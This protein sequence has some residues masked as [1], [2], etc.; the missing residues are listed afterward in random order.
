[1]G[2]NERLHPGT[3]MKSNKPA[4]PL[5]IASILLLLSSPVFVRAE[6]GVTPDRILI[7]QS[8]GLTGPAAPQIRDLT[9]GAQAYFDKLNRAGGIH[10]RQIQLKSLDDA[11]DPKRT[12]ENATRLIHEDGAFALFLF[13][14][15]PNVEAVIPFVEKERVPLVA[16]S[17]GAESMYIPA[18]RYLFPV[19][20][21]YDAEVQRMVDHMAKFGYARIAVFHEDAAFGKDVLARV[22][23]A[24]EKTTLTLATAAPYARGTTDVAGAAQ[25][26]V[27]SNSEAVVLAGQANALIAFIEV[28]KSKG[29]TPNY[30]TLSTVSNDAFIKGLGQNARGVTLTQVTPYPYSVASP[31]SK[32]FLDAIRDKPD[33]RPSYLAMEGFIGAKLLA[34]GLR[35]AGPAPTREKLVA[36][37]E[38]LQRHDLGGVEVTYGPGVR[39]GSNYTDITM[40]DKRGQLIH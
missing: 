26:V 21:P 35:R 2:Y 27:A 25:Q 33:V 10:G 15:T 16:P 40:I 36:A 17:S 37:L 13:R 14:G 20:S 32:E 1:M 19:R 11:I 29:Q 30:F 4:A 3:T 5:A 34:E 9:A 7:G 6:P 28:M 12:L 18:K 31:L 39:A 24:I 22:K 38:T 23:S 8:A